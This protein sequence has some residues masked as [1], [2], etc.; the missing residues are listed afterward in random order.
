M[1]S[2]GSYNI[3]RWLNQMD[4]LCGTNSKTLGVT[5]RC[6]ADID[7]NLTSLWSNCKEE[8]CH[9]LDWNVLLNA[10]YEILLQLEM[11]KK[12]YTNILSYIYY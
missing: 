3:D 1:N 9:G 6:A 2:V 4:L 12:V 11:P 5:N 10:P 8:T 7:S